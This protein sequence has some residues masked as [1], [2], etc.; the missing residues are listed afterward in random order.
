[1]SEANYHHLKS[2]FR[3]PVNPLDQQ[4]K[5]DWNDVYGD[6]LCCL[7]HLRGL[8]NLDDR[9]ELAYDLLLMLEDDSVM[10]SR[11]SYSYRD[12]I[13]RVGQIELLKEV[14]EI[15]KGSDRLNLV[16]NAKEILANLGLE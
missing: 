4:F 3:A 8:G 2:P 16:P 10:P 9:Q 14:I 6:L 5:M 15:V 12:F 13:E 11:R 7:E 1:M